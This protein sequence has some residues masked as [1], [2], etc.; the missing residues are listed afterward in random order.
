[1]S[2]VRRDIIPEPTSVREVESGIKSESSSAKGKGLGLGLVLESGS[3]KGLYSTGGMSW[4]G[5][6]RGLVRGQSEKHPQHGPGSAP[7]WSETNSPQMK[8]NNQSS[9]S[10]SPVQGLGLKSSMG[11]RETGGNQNEVPLS[12]FLTVSTHG[13]KS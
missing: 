13:K 6:R 8:S 9:V 3:G 5:M 7:L 11:K 1:M 4:K 2:N 12:Y 10:T